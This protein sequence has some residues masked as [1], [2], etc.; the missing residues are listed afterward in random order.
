MNKK[1]LTMA[2][3]A[4]LASGATLSTTASADV[5]VYGAAQVE[6]ASETSSYTYNY[7]IGGSSVYTYSPSDVKGR[8]VEDNARGRIGVKA[9]EDLGGGLTGLAKFEFKADTADGDAD[10][11]GGSK[12][13]LSKREML[14]GLKGGFGTVTLGRLKS[15]YKYLG[16]V[17]Y[18]PFVTTNLQARGNFGMSGKVGQGNAFG[19]N[20][21]M[22]DMISYQ[23][24]KIGGMA[25]V[26]VNYGL[27]ENG[28]NKSTAGNAGDFS[29]GVK[30]GQKNWEAFVAINND[31]YD[32]LDEGAPIGYTYDRSYTAT[33][34]GGKFKMGMHTIVGQYEITADEDEENLAGALYGGTYNHNNLFVGYTAKLGKTSLVAQIAQGSGSYDYANPVEDAEYTYDTTTSYLAI[35][36]IHKL[37][38]KTRLFA[39]YRQTKVESDEEFLGLVGFNIEEE[40]SVISV[41][42]RKDF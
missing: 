7:T 9:S 33:K 30:V 13:A 12:V 14:V 20:S 10:T 1:L 34:F 28:N 18:D 5:T 8:T 40:D 26:W 22:S 11:S 39:G 31:N 35:G 17:K 25:T 2:V 6:I 24:P 23:S 37:S 3:G 41:G 38:K 15:P 36:A 21:F 27:D 32:N 16:G 42:M 19:H 4:A 29:L